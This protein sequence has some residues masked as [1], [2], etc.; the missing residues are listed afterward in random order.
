MWMISETVQSLS[1]SL[2]HVILEQAHLSKGICVSGKTG[3]SI[4]GS[5]ET[6]LTYNNDKKKTNQF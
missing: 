4:S 6:K 1:D 2:G 5:V 3:T